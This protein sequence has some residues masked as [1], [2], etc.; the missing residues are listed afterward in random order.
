MIIRHGGNLF[1]IAQQHGWDWHD[2]LDLSASINPLGPSPLVRPAIEAALDRIAHYPGQEPQALESALGAAWNVDPH[3]VMAGSGATELV[4]F[5]ARAAWQGPVALVTP[6]WS[7][8]YRA[9]PTPSV[10]I[11]KTSSPGPPADSSSSLNP[12][13]P[14]APPSPKNSS[15]APSPLARAPSSSTRASSNSP[16]SPPPSRGVTAT[17]T[18]SFSARSPNFTPSPASASAP[19]S[20]PVN[21]CSASAGN[22]SP[23]R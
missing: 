17:P 15:A 21:G 11:P 3:F 20:A 2:V 19:S 5:V 18:S 10:S 22:G 14:P 9:F 4:H 1:A 8:F 13:I 6:V 7:E 16:A 23:G 12:P